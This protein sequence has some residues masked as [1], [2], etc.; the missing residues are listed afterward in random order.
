MC[1]PLTS[2]APGRRLVSWL[3]ALLLCSAAGHKQQFIPRPVTPV[4]GQVT[5]RVEA[6]ARAICRA[7]GID[8][9]HVGP[10]FPQGPL[11]EFFVPD[12]ILFLQELDAAESFMGPDHPVPLQ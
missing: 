11:W 5:A 7:K 6:V 4:P 1:R 12:A 10:P 8:P 3:L 2:S 9:D